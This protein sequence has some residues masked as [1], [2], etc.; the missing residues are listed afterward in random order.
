MHDLNPE[1]TLDKPKLRDILQN[2]PLI[3]F[4]KKVQIMKNKKRLTNRDMT[5]KFNI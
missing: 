5:T 3:L 1:A 4:I 2:K